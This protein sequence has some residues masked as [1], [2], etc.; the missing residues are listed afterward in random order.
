MPFIPDTLATSGQETTH[1]E[2]ALDHRERTL[3]GMTTTSISFLGFLKRHLLRM[4]QT[5]RFMLFV[6]DLT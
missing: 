4:S 6:T 3:A 1:T 5:L 2:V